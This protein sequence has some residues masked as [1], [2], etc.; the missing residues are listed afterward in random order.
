MRGR[1]SSTISDPVIVLVV[2]LALLPWAGLEKET[3][4]FGEQPVEGGKLGDAPV[5]KTLRDSGARVNVKATRAGQTGP[6]APSRSESGPLIRIDKSSIL[7]NEKNVRRGEIIAVDNTSESELTM[8]IDLPAKGFL[9]YQVIRKP[10]QT[11]VSRDALTRF[12]FPAD[13]GIYIILI[14]ETDHALIERLDGETIVIK[15]YEENALR[16]THRIP[17][18]VEASTSPRSVTNVGKGLVE[19]AKK[20]DPSAVQ[21]L[22]ACGV[23]VNASDENGVTALMWAAGDGHLELVNLLLESGANVNLRDNGGNTALTRAAFLG[24]DDVVRRLLD[25]GVNLDATNEYGVTALMRAAGVGHVNVVK[26]LLGKGADAGIKNQSGQ[27]A[28][29]WA[30]QAGH[31]D[32]VQLLRERGAEKKKKK[33][34]QVCF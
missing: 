26:L 4:N 11:R 6:S 8:G 20:G 25:Y 14:P 1:L 13:S 30:V 15:V 2:A 3:P 5:L 12:S 27:T 19:A 29:T 23:D 17:I 28:L 32:V 34:G 31:M 22:L 9:Y 24:Q 16:E 10:E 7:F 21:R 18:K 33:R